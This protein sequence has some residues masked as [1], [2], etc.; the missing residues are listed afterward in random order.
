MPDNNR[1]NNRDM[2]GVSLDPKKLAANK[3]AA[4]GSPASESRSTNHIGGKAR[5]WCLSDPQ[6]T[7]PST[8]MVLSQH[9]HRA[10]GGLGTEV[11][12]RFEAES[13]AMSERVLSTRLAACPGIGRHCG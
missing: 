8:K 6:G 3:L 10:A 5:P 4:S 2:D 11:G 12:A 1:D 9:V 7:L 13:E